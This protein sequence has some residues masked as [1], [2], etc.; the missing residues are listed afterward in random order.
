MHLEDSSLLPPLFQLFQRTYGG[1]TNAI[2]RIGGLTEG[3]KFPDAGSRFKV[4]S[5]VFQVWKNTAGLSCCLHV[6]TEKCM[7]GLTGEILL[8]EAAAEIGQN[9]MDAEM[10]MGCPA[11]CCY[12][13]SA[14]CLHTPC[15]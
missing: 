4:W 9:V 12:Q 2:Y 5:Q 10:L 8:T 3:I 7:G 6:Q 14:V 13:S 1:V 15:S 11:Q